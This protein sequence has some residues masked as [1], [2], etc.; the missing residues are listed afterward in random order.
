MFVTDTVRI[1][2]QIY[3][4]TNAIEKIER[5]RKFVLPTKYRNKYFGKAMSHTF[6]RIMCTLCT[7]QR[8]LRIFCFEKCSKAR[9]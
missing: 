3:I 9:K 8:T 6:L 5:T 2:T 1:I 7:F 4:F